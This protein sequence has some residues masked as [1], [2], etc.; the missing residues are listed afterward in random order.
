MKLDEK[1]TKALLENYDIQFAKGEHPV[2][3]GTDIAIDGWID[4]AGRRVVR[5]R[6]AAH[7]V[8]RLV[9]LGDESCEELVDG[10]RAHQHHTRNAAARQMLK[11]LFLHVSDLFERERVEQFSLDPVRLHENEYTVVDA[12]FFA[13]TAIHVTERRGRHARDRK[14]FHPS[15]TQ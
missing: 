4:D 6:S 3:P 14:T 11:H 8:E 15:G 13:S 9:P 12:A 10:L 2:A 7:A 5:A 1:T